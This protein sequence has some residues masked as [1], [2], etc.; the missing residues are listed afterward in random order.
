M[1]LQRQKLALASPL[2]LLLKPLPH[3]PSQWATWTQCLSQVQSWGKARWDRTCPGASAQHAQ[4]PGCPPGSSES[5]VLWGLFNKIL[6]SISTFS[7]YLV[8]DYSLKV[9]S[10]VIILLTSPFLTFYYI[11]WLCNTS[12]H[13]PCS[14]NLGLLSVSAL[15][16]HSIR[17]GRTRAHLAHFSFISS[18]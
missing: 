17:H 5:T 1:L 14:S 13:S 9:F 2:S 16:S 11:S 18:I 7:T 12:E 4:S 10:A 8:T 15:P 6:R 3:P